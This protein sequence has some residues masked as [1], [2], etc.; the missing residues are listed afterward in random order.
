MILTC[1][2]SAFQNLASKTRAMNAAPMGPAERAMEILL[3]SA[4]GG[5]FYGGDISG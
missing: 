2:S 1:V 4:R 3:N 5:T